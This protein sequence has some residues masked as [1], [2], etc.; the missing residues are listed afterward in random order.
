MIVN[1]LRASAARAVAA[2]IEAKGGAAIARRATSRARTDVASDRRRSARGVWRLQPL[3]N[4]AGIVQQAL[5]VDLTPADFDRMFAVHVRG[6][7]L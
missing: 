6:V 3:V 2:E 5:F 4:N 7:F 1:D